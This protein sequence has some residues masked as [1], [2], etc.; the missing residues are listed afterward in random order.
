MRGILREFRRVASA[1]NEL[2][3]GLAATLTAVERGRG[4]LF[5]LR[6]AVVSSWGKGLPARCCFAAFLVV[7]LPGLREE[8]SS[9][10]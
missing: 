9:E 10:I 1:W 8:Q 4:M 7:D 3:V 5:L 6:A 2:G